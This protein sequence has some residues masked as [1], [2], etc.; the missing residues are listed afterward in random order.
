MQ[1]VEQKRKHRRGIAEHLSRSEEHKQPKHKRE[2]ADGCARVGQD[3]I[4]AG[5][6][7]QLHT[8]KGG[9]SA[10]ID[11]AWIRVFGLLCQQR[12]RGNEFHKRRMLRID[13][14]IG[15][16]PVGVAGVQVGRLVEGLGLQPD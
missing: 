13:S 6:A 10:E 12:Q 1:H 15:V 11:I 7:H 2:D 14:E 8:A 3:G 9:L 16:Q 4:R 5:L